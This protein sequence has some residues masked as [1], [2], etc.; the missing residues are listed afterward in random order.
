VVKS[1]T[2]GEDRSRS[3]VRFIVTLAG[4]DQHGGLTLRD[5]YWLVMG[6]AAAS[7]LTVS[8]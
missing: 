7:R 4:G 1:Y 3:G 8:V 2:I 6:L 5:A